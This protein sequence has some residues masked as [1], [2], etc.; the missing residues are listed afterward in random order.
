[1][2]SLAATIS[3]SRST[4]PEGWTLP[5]DSRKAY[6]RADFFIEIQFLVGARKIS[7][8]HSDL[9]RNKFQSPMPL[10]NAGQFGVIPP[11]KDLT[12]SGQFLCS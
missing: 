10:R 7:Q 9:P 1:M 3:I 8:V 2:E 5:H 12:P 4:S 11:G 6:L